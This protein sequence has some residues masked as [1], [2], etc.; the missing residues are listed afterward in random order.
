MTAALS[1]V[2]LTIR[3]PHP[4]ILSPAGGEEPLR[5]AQAAV[6]ILVIG[7]GRAQPDALAVLAREP[8]VE[9]A[10]QNVSLGRHQVGRPDERARAR[11]PQRG[12]EVTLA[13]AGEDDRVAAHVVA[14][15]GQRRE[16][17][18]HQ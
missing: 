7:G 14:A 3:N 10:L 1:S 12:G 2:L 16:S 9:R 11:L 8:A 15:L 6:L 17:E 13:D 18:V 4:T 5:G